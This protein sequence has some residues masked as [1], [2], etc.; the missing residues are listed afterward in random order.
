[1]SAFRQLVIEPSGRLGWRDFVTTEQGISWVAAIGAA[2]LRKQPG[3]GAS[4]VRHTA[5]WPMRH[6]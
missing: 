3:A 6:R 4:R 2:R 1:M 5:P